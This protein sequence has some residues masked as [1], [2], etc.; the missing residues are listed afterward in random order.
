M[1]TASQA[2]AIERQ[3]SAQPS[4][5]ERVSRPKTR[6]ILGLMRLNFL[7]VFAATG[8]SRSEGWFCRKTLGLETPPDP[9]EVPRRMNSGGLGLDRKTSREP[10]QNSFPKLSRFLRYTL[11]YTRHERP[12]YGSGENATVL[13]T[14]DRPGQ[15]DGTAGTRRIAVEHEYHHYGGMLRFRKVTP[16]DLDARR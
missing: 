7:S 3:A 15:L 13:G 10:R 1:H 2:L 11:G 8:L 16:H 4:L 12:L 6:A 9:D 5:A 14:R